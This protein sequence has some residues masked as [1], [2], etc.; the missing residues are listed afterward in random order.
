MSPRCPACGAALLSVEAERDLNGPQ[1]RLVRMVRGSGRE[2]I[3]TEA[4]VER[5][6]SQ[7][8]DGGPLNAAG[9]IRQLVMDVNAVIVPHGLRVVT[10]PLGGPHARR[11]LE[12]VEPGA[13]VPRR[14]SRCISEGKRAAVLANKIDTHR[15][16]AVR[17]GISRTS[18]QRIRKKERKHGTETTGG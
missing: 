15:D 16:V 2:G 10:R 7:R 13:Y 17:H 8:V 11:F 3:S 14:E 5:F 18:V 12:Q 1:R 9:R 6:F 4:L